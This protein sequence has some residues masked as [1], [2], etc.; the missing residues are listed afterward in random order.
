MNYN[1][2]LEKTKNKHLYD[3]VVKSVDLKK[4][5]D[6]IIHISSKNL[7]TIF[8]MPYHFIRIISNNDDY[9]D[10]FSKYHNIFRLLNSILILKIPTDNIFLPL[11]EYNTLVMEYLNGINAD[12]YSLMTKMM[13][14]LTKLYSKIINA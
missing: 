11:L 12:K 8:I 14:I 5:I 1:Q 3:K 7:I 6:K 10:S 9:F 13:D 2:H 4:Q